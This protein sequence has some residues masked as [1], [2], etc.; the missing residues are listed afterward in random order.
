MPHPLESKYGLT[1]G[2]L[3]DAIDRRFRLKVA[4]EGAVAEVHFERKLRVGSQEGWIGEFETHD[5]DG[6]HDFT[7]FARP[8]NPIRVEVKTIRNG[9]TPR[10]EVQKTRNAK[11]DPSSRL[12]S[13]DQFDVL[14]VCVGR[15]TGNWTEFR[16]AIVARL[17][18]HK[19]H[20]HKLQV[21][22]AVPLEPPEGSPWFSRLQ[23]VIDELV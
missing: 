15:F 23:E 14:A 13:A 16:Y 8:G 17:P 3:L 1:S 18:R 9:A 10:V 6:T 11:D 7:V 12:Y 5:T 22:H 21:M 19:A 2:E 4:L 20:S